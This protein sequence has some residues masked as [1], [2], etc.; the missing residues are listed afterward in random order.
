V[1]VKRT[2]DLTRLG[3]TM[4]AIAL[5]LGI[6]PQTVNNWKNNGDE[7]YKPQMTIDSLVKLVA[8]L[9]H[10]ADAAALE[11]ELSAVRRGDAFHADLIPA[12]NGKTIRY[13]S[14]TLGISS[15]TYYNWKGA[16]HPVQLTLMQ[17]LALVRVLEIGN[18]A[19][20]LEEDF[21]FLGWTSEMATSERELLPCG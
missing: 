2:F 4:S 16:K 18:L 7:A 5:K 19:Q 1:F 8:L 13:I 6:T 11:V 12:F 20:K 15:Q 21:S 9:G 17:C 14:E 3:L 10:D